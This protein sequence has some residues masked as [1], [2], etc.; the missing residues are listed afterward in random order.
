[1]LA[2]PLAFALLALT[3]A[4]AAL[5]QPNDARPSELPVSMTISTVYSVALENHT[6]SILFGGTVTYQVSDVV[7]L[8]VGLRVWWAALGSA[9]CR[10]DERRCD[11]TEE[12]DAIAGLLVARLDPLRTRFV[13]FHLGAGLTHLREQ[14]VP[15]FVIRQTISLPFTLLG[16]VASDLRML[17]HFYVSPSVEL[18]RSFVGEDALSVSPGWIVQFGLGVTVS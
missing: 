1:M 9:G 2:R 14:S 4:R 13:Y 8:G 18:I 5:C 16:G 7:G 6:E 3:P 17:D 12:L 15:G 11:L 10:I